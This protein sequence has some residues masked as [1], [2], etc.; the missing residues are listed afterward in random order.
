MEAKV[1]LDRYLPDWQKMDNGTF[2]ENAGTNAINASVQRNKTYT[3]GLGMG[4]R[5]VI[6]DFWLG[7]IQAVDFGKLNSLDDWKNVVIKLKTS[8]NERFPSAWRDVFRIAHSQK[9]LSVYWKYLYCKSKV[10]NTPINRPLIMPLDRRVQIIAGLR[11]NEI[12][13]WGR[14]DDFNEYYSQLTLIADRVGFR[15]EELIDWEIENFN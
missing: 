5:L 6:R 1:F 9:S 11:I 4:N 2:R 12:L 13:P 7:S 3:A 15:V 8:M 14:I 10:L